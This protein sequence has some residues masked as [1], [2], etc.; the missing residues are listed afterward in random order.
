MSTEYHILKRGVLEGPYPE[1]EVIRQL[2]AG[3]LTDHDL[4]QTPQSY[5]WM[6]LHRLLGPR[7]DGEP[8]AAVP[9]P[10][11]PAPGFLEFINDIRERAWI[12]FVH[13]PWEAG[14]LCLGVGLI[15][16]LLTFWPVLLYGP[17]ML[18]ALSAG[19]LLFLRGRTMAGVVLCAAAVL[20]P[21]I[22]VLLLKP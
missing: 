17:C 8:V 20:L 9:A 10:T 3:E 12:A 11:P 2:D 21:I 6:P 16:A 14:L 4:A 7:G 5:Y 18:A 1:E 15:V 19:A 22:I 13:Y